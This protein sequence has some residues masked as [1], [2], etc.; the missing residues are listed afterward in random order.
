MFVLIQ[1]KDGPKE[2]DLN[3]RKAIRE[4]CLN[5]TG[6]SY[7]AIKECPFDDCPLHSF[8]SGQGKQNP[9]KRLLAI[10]KY[11]LWCMCGQTSEVSKC[12][13]FDCPLYVY[14]KGTA[15][16]SINIAPSEIK[17]HIKPLLER[18]SSN[19]MSQ[20]TEDLN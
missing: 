7:K 1:H 13:S 5:C 2:V 3:R 12:T 19:S 4:R 16:K 14:R 9:K 8:R 10:K 20:S 15:D 11:C 6:W 17:H 18:N